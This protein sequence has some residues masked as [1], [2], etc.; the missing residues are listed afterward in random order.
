[1]R[2]GSVGMV[3]LSD[4][5]RERVLREGPRMLARRSATWI[6]ESAWTPLEPAFAAVVSLAG[7]WLFGWPPDSVVLFSLACVWNGV[8]CDIAKLLFAGAAVD[9]DVDRDNEER[10]Y[11]AIANA[12]RAGQASLHPA[13]FHPYRPR[14]SSLFD[15]V[16]GAIATGVIVSGVRTEE[17]SL[18]AALTG[19]PGM[20]ISLAVAI[21][22]Q[23]L[24]TIV[25]IVRSRRPGEHPSL[26]VL[27]GTRG[28]GLLAL[29]VLVLLGVAITDAIGIGRPLSVAISFNVGLLLLAGMMA[30]GMAV[31]RSE[32]AW[33]REYLRTN[34]T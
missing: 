14:V 12:I 5:H 22:L 2:Q 4:E 18:A 27:A 7:L 30:G 17:R 23:W 34:G 29:M 16:F 28:L 1:M 11:W 10:F 19:E 24:M 21:A 9:R 20:F 13:H 3:P 8:F 33:L 6:A 26:R 32:A 25:G 31:Y 15:I